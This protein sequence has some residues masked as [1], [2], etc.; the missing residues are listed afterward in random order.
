MRLKQNLQFLNH[1]I[2]PPV[3][4]TADISGIH[5]AEIP[6]TQFLQTISKVTFQKWYSIVKLVVNNFSIN[7]VALMDTGA[8]QNRI[9]GG[10][11]PTKF[12]ERTKE[13][14]V[15]ANGGPLD[16]RYKLNKGYIQNNKYCFKNVFL[17]ISNIT[18][19]LIL[20][21]PF[22]TQIYPFNV[23]EQG[24]Q[25]SIM[26]NPITFRFLTSA[27]QKNVMELQSSSIF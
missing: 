24:I 23:S 8:Y 6:E 17:I 18:N 3:S 13:Q 21:T 11:V 5:D 7:T 27:H 4:S 25:T 14:L 15:I 16:I 10:I 9:K 2:N 20:G 26:G 22:L 19:D 1:K 12:C